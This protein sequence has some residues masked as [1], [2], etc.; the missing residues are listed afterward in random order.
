M[1]LDIKKLGIN[2]EGIAYDRKIPVF[3]SGCLPGETMDAVITEDHGNYK[4]AEVKRILKKSP[5]RI[6]PEC[7]YF[8]I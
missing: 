7:R 2:G 3:L 1:I 8:N 4:F 5:S 6:D